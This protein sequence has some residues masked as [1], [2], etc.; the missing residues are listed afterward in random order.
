MTS[1]E[2]FAAF[3]RSDHPQQ[4]SNNGGNN[5]TP[6]DWIDAWARRGQGVSRPPQAPKYGE[7]APLLMPPISHMPQSA[8]PLSHKPRGRRHARSSSDY[9]PKPPATDPSHPFSNSKGISSAPMNRSSKPPR[10]SHHPLLPSQPHQV[11]SG[12]APGRGATGNRRVN[13][14]RRVK[15]DI[16]LALFGGGSVGGGHRDIT[17]ADLLKNFPNPRWGGAAPSIKPLSHSRQ[18]SRT[19]SDGPSFDGNGSVASGPSGYGTIASDIAGGANFNPGH[20]LLHS[21]GGAKFGP[22]HHGLQSI[23]SVEIAPN[24][25]RHGHVRQMSDASARSVTTDLA[26]SALFKTVTETGRI[27]MQLPKD[28]FRILMDSTLEAGQVYK[29]KLVDSED[30]FFLEFYTEPDEFDSLGN[31]EQKRL[32]P[33]LYVMAVDSTLYRRMMDEVIQ[34]RSMPFGL[35]FCGHHEDVRHPDITVASLI[36]GA[37]I[38]VGLTLIKMDPS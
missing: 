13:S 8:P 11:V 32:P 23:G 20:R 24:A 10:A 4:P 29:R 6:S 3:A 18:R 19:G 14:H 15:S 2:E 37:L 22:G 33:D 9:V 30:E 25:K 1:R 12:L 27:Q 17:K 7:Q 16:P 36:V 21:D 34:S 5:G 26:K 31:E 28:A 35:F 38:I